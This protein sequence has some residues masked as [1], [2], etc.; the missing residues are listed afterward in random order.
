M[1]PLMNRLDNYG[2]MDFVALIA[3]SVYGML[4][5]LVL[6][7]LRFVRTV[8]RAMDGPIEGQVA[9]PA[10]RPNV[11]VDRPPIVSQQPAARPIP[12]RVA[13]AFLDGRIE[14][15]DNYQDGVAEV[16]RDAAW[17]REGR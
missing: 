14:E 13:D 6:S 10:S 8:L 2:L 17:R 9:E 5:L 1:D 4:R 12:L 11:V 3:W 16:P 7:F 15:S